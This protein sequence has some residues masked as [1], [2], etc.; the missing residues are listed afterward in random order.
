MERQISFCC[1][2]NYLFPAYIMLES[3]M[4]SNKGSR[5]ITH[6]FTDDLSEDSIVKFDSI[7]CA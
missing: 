6:T 5:F 4:R 2:D 7:L 1:D 3:L